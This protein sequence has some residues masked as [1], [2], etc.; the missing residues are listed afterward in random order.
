MNENIRRA[1]GFF[2][3][4]FEKCTLFSLNITKMLY[5]TN[6]CFVRQVI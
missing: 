2:I 5:Q 3:S 1:F 4:A 6:L